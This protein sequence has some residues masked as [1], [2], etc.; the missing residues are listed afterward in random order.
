MRTVGQHLRGRRKTERS[1]AQC[2]NAVTKP[3]AIRAGTH[4]EFDSAS[5]QAG[6]MSANGRWIAYVSDET[7]QREVYAQRYPDLGH[8]VRISP[9]GGAEPRW[10]PT[11]KELFFRRGRGLYA[12]EVPQ[13]DEGRFGQP[14]L[15]F[16]GQFVEGFAAVANYDV[17]Q[18]GKHFVMVDG[19]LGLTAG[20][21]DVHL[22]FERELEQAL[23]SSR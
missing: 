7:G 17:A 15:L 14:H 1:R 2:R 4:V 6:T 19:G 9:S 5:E 3:S 12:V 20:R 22:H 11:G 8:K 16:E 13:S 18:D 21:L 10:S 23:S